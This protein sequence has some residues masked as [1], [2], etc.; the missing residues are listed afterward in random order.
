MVMAMLSFVS[1]DALMKF[2]FQ[3]MTV[4]Q[5]IFLRGVISLPLLAFLAQRWKSFNVKLKTS[6]RW[7]L[8]IRSSAELAATIC[9]LT[10]LAN[11]PLA[12]VTAILQT[13]PL[14]VTVFAALFFQESVGWRRW[15]AIS[16]G[17]IGVL[18]IIQ[19]GGE[20]F[21]HYTILALLTVGLVT[22]RD[23][24]TRRLSS[25]VPSLF[26]AFLA[27]LPV[28]L[29]GG[30]VTSID[31]WKNVENANILFLFFAGFAISCAHLFAVMAMR[32]G[33]I[34]FVA[35]FRYTGIVW[36]ILFGML[37]FAELPDTPT[38]IGVT[39]VISMGIYT[40]YRQS[41]RSGAQKQSQ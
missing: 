19:P 22:I 14:T 37:I 26:V 10:A 23:T 31:G 35:P 25:S 3:D 12:N 1:N 41:V 6:D 33:D 11:M 8:L 27:S 5:A 36:A 28:I 34:S 40:F 38:I 18:I 7:F 24:V 32:I 15:A 29:Y 39:I 2:V 30:I 20:D 16:I 21:N 17:F 13:V 9:F 4:A